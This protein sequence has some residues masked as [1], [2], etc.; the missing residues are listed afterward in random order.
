MVGPSK[1]GAAGGQSVA[2]L[3]WFPRLFQ[4]LGQVTSPAHGVLGVPILNRIL[5]QPLAEGRLDFLDGHV[6][7]LQVR[8]L[9]VDLRVSVSAGRLVECRCGGAPA[10][11]LAGSLYDFLALATRREDPDTLFFQRRLAMEGDAA[12]GL[13]VKNLLDEIEGGP[14]PA[15]LTA[16]LGRALDL[17]DA[18]PRR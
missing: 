2:A 14:L 15:P 1:L 4:H 9:G 7:T 6:V 12:L 8:D 16:I 17:W 10:L 5:A 13:Q 11:V 18:M 3:L